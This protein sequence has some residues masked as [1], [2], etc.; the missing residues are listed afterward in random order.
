MGTHTIS[1][2]QTITYTNFGTSTTITFDGVTITV[3]C[4]IASVPNPSPPTS[5]NYGLTYTLYDSQLAIDLT[6]IPFT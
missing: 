4:T 3:G 5:A 2:V 1:V 6:N